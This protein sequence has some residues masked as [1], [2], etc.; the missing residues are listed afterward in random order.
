[1]DEG[2][3]P[4]INSALESISHHEVGAVPQ[5]IEVFVEAR[6]IIAV[7]GVA[8]DDVAA[9]SRFNP[10]EQRRAITA[11]G[12]AHD[13][14]AVAA[15]DFPRPIGAAVVRDQDLSGQLFPSEERLGLGNARPDGFSLIE[16][17]HED[18]ELK[19]GRPDG[20][21]VAFLDQGTHIQLSRRPDAPK[22]RG[23]GDKSQLILTRKGG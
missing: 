9:A 20:P 22:G 3:R 12:D 15:G 23:Q 13:P 21:N 7:V 16:A 1:M 2:H 5:L 8:H 18:R 4:R 19:V 10:P 17:R 14:R 11:S 6:E